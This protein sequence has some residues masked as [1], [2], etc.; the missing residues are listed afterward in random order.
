MVK[1]S[2][3]LQLRLELNNSPKVQSAKHKLTTEIGV[4]THPITEIG[5]DT[6]PITEIGVHTNP[7][8]NIVL[9]THPV[10]AIGGTLLQSLK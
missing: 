9:R 6:H 7:V 1:N 10:T 2:S 3:T 8:T 4:Q 5:L